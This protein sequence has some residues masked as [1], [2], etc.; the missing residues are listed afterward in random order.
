MHSISIQINSI[1]F[2]SMQFSS[3]L[4]KV[5]S[6][7]VMCFYT[8]INRSRSQQNCIGNEIVNDCLE[9]LVVL[10]ITFLRSTIM[11]I[12]SGVALHGRIQWNKLTGN[13]V[14]APQ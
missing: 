6:V 10:S 13:I 11:Q 14:V 5:N 7:K 3:A 4:S 8:F 12:A 2:N 9:G 1:Q